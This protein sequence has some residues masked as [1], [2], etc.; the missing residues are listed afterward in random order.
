MSWLQANT[1]NQIQLIPQSNGDIVQHRFQYFQLA[2]PVVSPSERA[3][4]QGLLLII[5]P[6][7][8]TSIALP[9]QSL[10]LCVEP[11]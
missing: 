2:S 5:P 11:Q 6:Y 4:L 1:S 3:L 8:H 10:D 7:L 9:P